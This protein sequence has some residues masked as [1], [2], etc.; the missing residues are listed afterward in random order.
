MQQDALLEPKVMAFTEMAPAE[1]HP[2][3]R[4]GDTKGHGI[5]VTT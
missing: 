1:M 5:G 2:R 4:A 3:G